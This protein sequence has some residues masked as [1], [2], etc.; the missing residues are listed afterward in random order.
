MLDGETDRIV[1]QEIGAD[2]CLAKPFGVRELL[3]RIKVILRRVRS[4]PSNLRPDGRHALV[5]DG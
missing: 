1:G 3:A 2:D 5:F 4:L